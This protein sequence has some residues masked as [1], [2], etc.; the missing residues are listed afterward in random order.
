MFSR[1]ILEVWGFPFVRK[2]IANK[3]LINFV[4]ISMLEMVTEASN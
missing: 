1:I 2:N 4:K 3:F